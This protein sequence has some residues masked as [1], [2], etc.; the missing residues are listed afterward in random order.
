MIWIL[1]LAVAL[2]VGILLVLDG[3]HPFK[4]NSVW[5]VFFEGFKALGKLSV[6]L[7]SVLDD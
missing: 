2:P 3:E 1:V 7:F 5:D 6:L 4:R